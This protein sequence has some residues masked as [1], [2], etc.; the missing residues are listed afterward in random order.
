M[1]KN[2][3]HKLFQN[4]IWPAVAGNVAWSFF[5]ILI[6]DFPTKD[7][8]TF[9]RL[10]LL[11]LLAIYL[12]DDWIVT[13]K[14]ADNL[15]DLYWIGDSFHAVAI[16]ILSLSIY[17]NKEG[18]MFWASISVLVIPIIAHLCGC[19]ELKNDTGKKLRKRIGLSSIAGIGLIVFLSTYFLIDE[20]F[21]Y[22]I[23]IF[24]IVIPWFL[25][26]DKLYYSQD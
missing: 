12:G 7:N 5:S 3:T 18:I 9:T 25:L 21:S 10:I 19:W 6:S 4:L 11:L 13:E 22:L 1:N 15:K 16:T 2:Q 20:K 23:S 26:R 17:S 14:E 24:A 8:F